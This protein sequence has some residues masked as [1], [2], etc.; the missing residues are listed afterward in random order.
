LAIREN[1]NKIS[2]KDFVEAVEIIKE[3]E[4]SYNVLNDSFN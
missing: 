2:Q 1:K 3:D 4:D